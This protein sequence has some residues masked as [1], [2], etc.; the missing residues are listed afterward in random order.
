MVANPRSRVTRSARSTQLAEIPPVPE[1]RPSDEVGVVEG[2]EHGSSA[3]GNDLNSEG[4][5]IRVLGVGKGRQCSS[6]SRSVGVA[7][8]DNPAV[9]TGVNKKLSMAYSCLRTSE[10]GN[11]RMCQCGKRRV[12]EDDNFYLLMCPRAAQVLRDVVSSGYMLALSRTS[13]EAGRM[14]LK[15]LMHY[16]HYYIRGE[17]YACRRPPSPDPRHALCH[18]FW[19]AM[20]SGKVAD[21]NPR[22]RSQINGANGEA[23]G[24]DDLADGHIGAQNRE[25]ARREAQNHRYAR[26]VQGRAP[27]EPR[28][29]L[30]LEQEAAAEEARQQA[31]REVGRRLDNPNPPPVQGGGEPQPPPGNPDRP[32]YGPHLPPPAAD[33]FFE[34]DDDDD[35][36]IRPDP[37]VIVGT[38][39][40]YLVN[41]VVYR[42]VNEVLVPYDPNN[43]IWGGVIYTA[44]HRV[45]P[46]NRVI[47]NIASCKPGVVGHYRVTPGVVSTTASPFAIVSNFVIQARDHVWFK[48]FRIGLAQFGSVA[49]TVA[50]AGFFNL[51][52]DGPYRYLT[53]VKKDI[54]IFLPLYSY[55]RSDK[56]ASGVTPDNALLLARV[57]YRDF[58]FLPIEVLI[59]TLLYFTFQRSAAMSEMIA[60]TQ[61]LSSY[62]VSGR[63]VTAYREP[64]TTN[65]SAGAIIAGIDD[66]TV[67]GF[68]R[69]NSEEEVQ[70][71]R[72]RKLTAITRV[73]YVPSSSAHGS[74]ANRVKPAGNKFELVNRFGYNVDAT[75]CDP[76]P[77]FKTQFDDRYESKSYQ[78][79]GSCFATRM[80]VIDGKLTSEVEK[81]F[82]RLSMSRPDEEL[83]RMN[84]I[85][86]VGP[87]LAQ[88]VRLAPNVDGDITRKILAND[89]DYQADPHPLYGVL[90][91][92]QQLICD[93]HEAYQSVGMDPVELAAIARDPIKAMHE[94]VDIIGGPK[95][96][97]CHVDIERYRLDPS[98]KPKSFNMVKFKPDE[99]QKYKMVNGNPVLKFGRATI[100]IEGSDWV[101]ANPPMMYSMKHIIEREI[102]ITRDPVAM[103]NPLRA[104]AVSTIS[105]DGVQIASD[106]ALDYELW[107]RA[108][109]SETSNEQ[110][111]AID[112]T[113]LNWVSGRRNRMA[114][115]SHGDDIHILISDDDGRVSAL[116]AD[117]SDNDGSY[118]DSLIRLEAQ[119]IAPNCD[120]S[121]CYAQL[122]NPLLLINPANQREKLLVRST[123]GML[124]CSGGIGTT[125]G[126]SKGSFL[127]ILSHALSG[128]TRGIVD[129]A[130]AVGFN[131]TYNEFTIAESCFLSSFIYFTVEDG[132]RV[133]KRMK[134]L[135]SIARNFG[136][137]CGDLPGPAK[138]SV[139]DRWKDYARGVI[140]GYSGEPD[141]LFMRA[142]R[143]KHDGWSFSSLCG[144]LRSTNLTDADRGI[145]RHYYPL[146]DLD[147]GEREYLACVNLIHQ[148]PT[149]GSVIACA[150]I[151][152][153]MAKRYGMEPVLK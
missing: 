128:K 4:V 94:Y 9:T 118:T 136:R 33:I 5:R 113:M 52:E 62:A 87:A 79:I 70:L 75:F 57:A 37:E 107:Y 28:G 114:A 86:A 3:A 119:Q 40:H 133:P 85:A 19:R 36:E 108:C 53:K 143:I 152:R 27:R 149:F 144:R 120:P 61:A 142:L 105:I 74:G 32:I 78:T 48:N 98:V 126:N 50:T 138:R 38:R 25:R 92:L 125:Y 116:E 132:L 16:Q 146:E 14:V 68:Y 71:W 109:L 60:T 59:E 145:I 65:Y 24:S 111:A 34:G 47:A 41:G 42:R 43:C 73:P 8:N 17:Y 84:Q 88:G 95:A 99:A 112:A 26:N 15:E 7:E 101:L 39:N 130:R 35:N 54:M 151:D 58:A 106:V 51:W 134:C 29:L 12:W 64:C 89:P 22:V 103:V 148:A 115:I 10:G 56:I 45:E 13:Q 110:L 66:I 123:R 121:T 6:P 124:R 137:F 80:M 102:M 139:A 20:M 131:V 153:I 72:L 44:A 93:T 150:F 21:H 63:R 55:L 1:M 82:L 11:G 69:I 31:A 23:T 141:T 100:S 49:M 2:L 81:C 18:A 135:A 96:A 90:T 122:A 46:P 83:L 76:Y 91:P 147:Q 77:L 127:V 117:I 97:K 104:G 67:E 129:S 140:R 30:E